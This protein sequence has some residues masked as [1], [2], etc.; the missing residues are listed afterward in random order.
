VIGWLYFLSLP[1]TLVGLASSGAHR[2]WAFSSIGVAVAIAALT[3]SGRDP[4]SAAADRASARRW[5]TL[6][7]SAAMG[8]FTVIGVASY[9]SSVNLYER[10]PG[11]Y[12]LGA[13]GRDLTPD[14][15]RSADWFADNVGYGA[16]VLAARRTFVAFGAYADAT[17]PAINGWEIFFPTSLSQGEVAKL[18]ASD[19]QYVAV[20][21][22]LATAVP[23]QS[24]FSVYEPTPPSVPL[25]QAS[26]AKFASVP[27]LKLVHRD[28]N[29]SIYRVVR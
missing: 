23:Q 15:L 1:L 28:A 24:Y 29:I 12:V 21:D 5:R 3:A 16:S 22:R 14:L 25:P 17:K 27:W 2:T 19:T 18:L 8:A 10:F 20:D 26:I 13:D 11:R 9:A 6:R 7:I 4:I